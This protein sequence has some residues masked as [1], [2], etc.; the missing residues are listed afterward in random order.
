MAQAA[1]RNLLLVNGVFRRGT[2]MGRQS[3]LRLRRRRIGRPED[4]AVLHMVA[5]PGFQNYKYNLV[6]QNK[7]QTGSSFKTFV[8]ATLHRTWL[9]PE[10]QIDGTGPCLFSNPN[11]EPD[12]Y[13]RRTSGA[14]PAGSGHLRLRRWA[15]STAYV[16]PDRSSG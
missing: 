2:S 13:R 7:R 9:P 5:G 16:R 14:A 4:R 11:G 3:A 12:P 1:I 6:T 10:D 8:L 15:P